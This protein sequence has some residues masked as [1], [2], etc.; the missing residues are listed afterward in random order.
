MI[1]KPKTH[2]HKLVP[3]SKEV[4]LYSYEPSQI[5]GYVRGGV[6]AVDTIKGWKCRC[7][8]TMAG[9]LERRVA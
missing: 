4:H 3:V 5:G 8:Y 9:D 6:V 2:K 1:S 7:G